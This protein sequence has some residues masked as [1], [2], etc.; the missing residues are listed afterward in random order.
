M[1]SFSILIYNHHT[2]Y[3]ILVL[4]NHSILSNFSID[5]TQSFSS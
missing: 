2:I 3:Q 4:E 5:F 1:D